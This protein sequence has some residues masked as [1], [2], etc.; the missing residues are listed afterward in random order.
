ML[1]FIRD[2]FSF[3][4]VRYTSIEELSEDIVGLAKSKMDQV[5]KKLNSEPV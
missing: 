5:V 4:K 2:M 1:S 3:D